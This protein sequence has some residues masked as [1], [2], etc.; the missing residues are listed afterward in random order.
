MTILVPRNAALSPHE[1]VSWAYWSYPQRHSAA[2]MARTRYR[3]LVFIPLTT[4]VILDAGEIVKK[5]VAAGARTQKK[6]E[7]RGMA[8]DLIHTYSTVV[9][10]PNTSPLFY[11]WVKKIIETNYLELLRGQFS[12]SEKVKRRPA[13][14]ADELTS[15]IRTRSPNM[16]P[17]N[18]EKTHL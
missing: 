18:V 6:A 4:S 15:T 9:F 1:V 17:P 2:Q 14:L 5:L 10:Q 13:H 11:N 3:V 7:S 16:P 8:S 12:S